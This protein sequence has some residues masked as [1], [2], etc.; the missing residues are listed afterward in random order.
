MA[1]DL[2]KRM[3]EEREITSNTDRIYYITHAI[4]VLSILYPK[5]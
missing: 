2:I 4:E 1:Q 5:N 3:R